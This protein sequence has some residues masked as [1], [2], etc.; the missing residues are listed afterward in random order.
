MQADIISVLSGHSYIR[1]GTK[2]VDK[3]RRMKFGGSRA[4]MSHSGYQDGNF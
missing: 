2:K 4:P 1:S 3:E